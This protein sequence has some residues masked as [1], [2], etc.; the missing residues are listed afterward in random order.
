MYFIYMRDLER[1]T[2]SCSY[3]VSRTKPNPTVAETHRSA[4][5]VGKCAPVNTWTCRISGLEQTGAVASQS[6]QLNLILAQPS[7][8]TH[9]GQN[10]R[11]AGLAQAS[12]YFT[13][14]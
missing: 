1:N 3:R 13:V 14:Q 12:Q 10:G 2:Y 8:A 7:D 9:V 4:A 5:Q 11:G 6:G